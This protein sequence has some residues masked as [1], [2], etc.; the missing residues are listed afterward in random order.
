MVKFP[1]V[2][3]EAN[4]KGL[5]TDVDVGFVLAITSL[6]HKIAYLEKRIAELESK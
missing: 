2:W 4:S 3:R 5:I 6:A 1:M